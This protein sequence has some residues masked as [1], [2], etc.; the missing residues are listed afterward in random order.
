VIRA[1]AIRRWTPTITPSSPPRAEIKRAV[2][3][4]GN[5]GDPGLQAIPKLERD[6]Y[7]LAPGMAIDFQA[8]MS[9]LEVGRHFK[10]TM[11]ITLSGTEVPR[12]I[13]S[14]EFVLK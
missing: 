10:R 3:S 5:P 14:E 12:E 9:F 13:A 7:T 2:G 11:Y 8:E 4:Y 6:R 1:V